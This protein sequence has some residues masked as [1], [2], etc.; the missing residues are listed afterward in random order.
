FAGI[1]LVVMYLSILGVEFLAPY[2]QNSRNVDFIFAQPQQIH[3]FDK[4]EFVGPFVYAY[5]YRLDMDTLKRIYTENT[6][7]PQKIR[8]F[9]RGDGYRFWGLFDSNMPLFCPPN[10]G[11]L[12]LLG[13]DRLGRDLFTRIFYGARVSLTIGLVGVT[14]S[15]VL[16]MLFG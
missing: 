9:C 2:A 14:V 5:D 16:G 15:F 6:A 1:V 8:F 3:L 7:K 4:G 12:F 13:S 11:T 10:G